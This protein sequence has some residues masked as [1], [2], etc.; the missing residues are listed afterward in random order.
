MKL[1]N[2]GAFALI[3]W[4]CQIMWM[5]FCVG[6]FSTGNPAT[7][8]TIQ[9]PDYTQVIIETLI[10]FLPGLLVLSIVLYKYREK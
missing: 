2:L 3:F 9:G 5:C 10:Y 6:I 8:T 4:F 1:E 7:A